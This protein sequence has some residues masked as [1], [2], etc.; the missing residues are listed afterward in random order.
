MNSAAKAATTTVTRWWWIRHAPVTVYD[1]KV[2]GQTDVPGNTSDSAAFAALAGSLPAGAQWVV[3]NLRRT[4][5]T[6][7]AVAGAGL[8]IGEWVADSALA[9][10]HFGDWQ[11]QNRRE[12]F[13]QNSEWHGFW[14]APADTAPPGGESFVDLWRRVAPAID[15]L[16]GDYAGRDIVAVA[17]GGTIRAALGLALGLQPAGA[18]GFSVDNLSVTRIDRISDDGGN[19]AWQVGAV[20]L[21]PGMAAR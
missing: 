9:E 7:A 1:G 17:H 21:P 2:Y 14:L 3:S 5:D 11:G 12:V 19:V 15:R 6:A 13:R 10:Q 8:K 4:H 18:L 16:S 20:N